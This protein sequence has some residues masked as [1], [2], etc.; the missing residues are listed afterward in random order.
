MIGTSLVALLAVASAV[1]A[2]T[3]SSAPVPQCL[4]TCA[5]ASCPDTSDIQCLCVTKNPEITNC[6]LSSCNSEDLA[7]A[8]TLAAAQCGTP[9]LSVSK[10]TLFLAGISAPSGSSAA[11]I[12]MES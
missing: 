7:T 9:L 12:G 5:A 6:V 8:R 3:P 4:L 11:S 2:Q 10:L 1:V